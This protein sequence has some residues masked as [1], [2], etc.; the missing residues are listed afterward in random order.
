MARRDGHRQA[1]GARPRRRASTAARRRARHQ[2]RRCEIRARRPRPP[3]RE[4]APRLL[5]GPG[6]GGDRSPAL[7]FILA[8][9]RELRLRCTREA[10]NPA[11]A[12]A[13]R[14]RGAVARRRYADARR[15]ALSCQTRRRG[16]AA[17][18]DLS[19][20]RAAAVVL[21][22]ARRADFGARSPRPRGVPRRLGNRR[23]K[24]STAHSSGNKR[25]PDAGRAKHRTRRAQV[26]GRARDARRAGRRALADAALPRARGQPG[27]APAVFGR[28]RRRRR[29]G[30]VSRRLDRVLRCHERA[31]ARRR[32]RPV[33]G[34]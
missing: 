15:A 3:A 31:R 6:K 17:L 20:R 11:T 29:R 21:Q 9:W 34:G 10:N 26:S 5:R 2:P 13:K 19:K 33:L 12:A 28:G 18:N 30:R 25:P 1:P 7:A 24:L 16:A 8:W 14:F 23:Q 22:R 27:G 4:E 32:R